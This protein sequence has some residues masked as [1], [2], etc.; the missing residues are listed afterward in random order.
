MST[1]SPA[2]PSMGKPWAAYKRWLQSNHEW[3]ATIESTVQTLTWL[4]PDLLWDDTGLIV[5]G[6]K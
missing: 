2:H 5:E 6:G 4:L 3:L 1:D